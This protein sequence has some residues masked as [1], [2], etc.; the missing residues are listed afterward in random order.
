MKIHTE[1]NNL[2]GALK[3]LMP[4]LLTAISKD[5]QESVLKG[6]G[7]VKHNEELAECNNH[8]NVIINH[9]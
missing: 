4:L 8:E 2:F 1:H 5:L 9:V 6:W 3:L 7:K